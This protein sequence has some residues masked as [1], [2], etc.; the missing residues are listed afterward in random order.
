VCLVGLSLGVPSLTAHAPTA[1]RPSGQLLPAVHR[2][3]GLPPHTTVDLP[4]GASKHWQPFAL[5]SRFVLL[6]WS[7]NWRGRASL[8]DNPVRMELARIGSNRAEP[9]APGAY[10][11]SGILGRWAVSWPWIVGVRYTTPGTPLDWQLW[12]GN[13]V[14]GKGRILDHAAGMNDRNRRAYPDFAL[15]GTRVIWTSAS[16]VLSKNDRPR[17]QVIFFDLRRGTRRVV[18]QGA[19]EIRYSSPAVWGNDVVWVSTT[20][21]PPKAGHPVMDLLRAVLPHGSPVNMTLNAQSMGISDEPALWQQYLLFKQGPSPYSIGDIVLWNTQGNAFPAWKYPGHSLVVD[22]Q[23]EAPS[24]GDGL[25]IWSTAG[26]DTSAVFDVPSGHLW[27]LQNSRLLES[28]RHYT[29]HWVLLAVHGRHVL[30]ERALADKP[31]PVE[32][33]VWEIPVLC[34]RAQDAAGE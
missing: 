6:V 32:H 25:A 15:D 28:G 1:C 34:G 24:F 30:V 22:H 26:M 31:G 2:E 16:Y 5:D 13:V 18:A 3:V 21:V 12:A 8:R 27:V 4:N 10:P 29:Y 17:S 14:T 19:P 11:H 20:P 9:V 23:A 7:P 33:V